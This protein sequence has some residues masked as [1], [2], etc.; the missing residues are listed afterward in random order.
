LEQPTA[1]L[2]IR[3]LPQALPVHLRLISLRSADATD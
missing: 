2:A 3:L 1:V